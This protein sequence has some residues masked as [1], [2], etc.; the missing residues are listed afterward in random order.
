MAA[1]GELVAGIRYKAHRSFRAHRHGVGGSDE[2]D[3]TRRGASRR[4]ARDRG[5]R[6]I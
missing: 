6:G 1:G 5:Q 3:K 2:L 4:E